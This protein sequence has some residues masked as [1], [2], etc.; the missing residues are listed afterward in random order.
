M[1]GKKSSISPMRAMTPSFFDM[2]RY[3][4]T[5]SGN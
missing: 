5:P 2:P 4:R 1:F 3:L